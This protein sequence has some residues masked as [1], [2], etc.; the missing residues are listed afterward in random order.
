MDAF[1][2]DVQSIPIGG[3]PATPTLALVV[4]I[5]YTA[6]SKAGD[7]GASG[8]EGERRVPRE[9]QVGRNNCY[10]YTNECG[11]RLPASRETHSPTHCLL[12]LLA[13]NGVHQETAGRRC[14]TIP[15]AAVFVS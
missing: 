5:V 12:G 14:P 13:P 2:S 1:D 3:D 7:G 8:R 6:D 15:R 11:A 4:R 9:W 10:E